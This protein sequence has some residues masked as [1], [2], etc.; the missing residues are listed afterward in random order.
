MRGSLLAGSE[1]QARR[2]ETRMCLQ[3]SRL[4]TLSS[5]PLGLSGWTSECARAAGE[6]SDADGVVL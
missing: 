5:R 3:R 4:P 1:C 2:S 6:T